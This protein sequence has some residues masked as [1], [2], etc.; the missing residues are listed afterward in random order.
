MPQITRTCIWNEVLSTWNS[1]NIFNLFFPPLQSIHHYMT[2]VL[3]VLPSFHPHLCILEQFLCASRISVPQQVFAQLQ[4]FR[5][6]VVI[7]WKITSI[8][9][10]HVQS[11]LKNFQFFNLRIT[12]HKDQISNSRTT[13]YNNQQG[14]NRILKLFPPRLVDVFKRLQK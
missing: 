13:S 8:Y 5:F 2:Y 14:S 10:C 11:G 4:Q 12:L 6:N 7:E 9:N 1:Q 3:T